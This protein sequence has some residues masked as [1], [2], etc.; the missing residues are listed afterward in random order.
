MK[1]R[2]KSIS[3]FMGYDYEEEL[4]YNKGK[5]NFS[6]S[7]D[8]LIPVW[9][10][11]YPERPKI[12]ICSDDFSGKKFQVS[13]GY[14]PYYIGHGNTIEEAASIATLKAIQGGGNNEKN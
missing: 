9:A 12:D 10:K 8:S 7:L 5:V 2:N 3:I 11:L 1:E 6:D 4:H 13:I 14:Y